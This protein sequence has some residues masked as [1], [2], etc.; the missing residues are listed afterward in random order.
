MDSKPTESPWMTRQEV[1]DYFKVDPMT[2]YAWGR[3]STL[4]AYKHGR[5]I[6][7]RRAEVEALLQPAS[8]EAE[9]E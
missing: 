8:G 5:F 3:N 4:T 7:Y 2:I 1:A 6:R 9:A